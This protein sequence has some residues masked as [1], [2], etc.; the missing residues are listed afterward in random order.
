MPSILMLFYTC[1][2][3]CLSFLCWLLSISSRWCIFSLRMALSF[4]KSSNLQNAQWPFKSSQTEKIATLL[5]LF[6]TK[7]RRWTGGLDRTMDICFLAPPTTQT[8]FALTYEHFLFTHLSLSACP[9]S[10]S[11]CNRNSS[12]SLVINSSLRDELS[13]SMPP[14]SLWSSLMRWSCCCA[15]SWAS[16]SWSLCSES[17]LMYWPASAWGGTEKW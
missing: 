16:L 5:L 8:A 9:S 4:S 11:S 17:C 6:V 3:I 15:L 10:F 12:A 14:I 13:C 2:I 1:S 7:A